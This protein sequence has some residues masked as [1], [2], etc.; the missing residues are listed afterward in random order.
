M[1]VA[2]THNFIFGEV[3]CAY[4]TDTIKLLGHKIHNGSVRPHPDRVK[5]LRELPPPK[6][7]K[8]QQLVMGYLHIMHFWISY[9]SDKIKLLVFNRVFPLKDQTLSSFINLKSE[10][11]DVPLG[12]INEK[13]PLTVKTDASDVEI[14]STLNQNNRSV[15]FWSR[16]LRRNELTQFSVENKSDGNC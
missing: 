9:Y 8:E 12:V 4:S 16:S 7:T 2:K 15:A 3:K 13:D 1:S 5:T 14:S 6:S 11:A 10:L